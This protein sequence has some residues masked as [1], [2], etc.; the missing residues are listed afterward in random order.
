[1]SAKPP[2][3]KNWDQARETPPTIDTGS[4]VK[5]K[6]W[7]RLERVAK[8]VSYVATFLVVLGTAIVSKAATL[9]MVKQLATSPSNIPLCNTDRRGNPIIPGNG[10]ADA[11]E[12]EVDF[13]CEEDDTECEDDRVV[14]RVAWIW[15]LAFAFSLPQLGAFLR[16]VR[17]LFI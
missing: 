6:W 17:G 3:V 7:S 2:E 15:A 13:T 1:M 11:T 5:S 4:A 8:V 10:S 12:Y 9:F 14:E 16:Y